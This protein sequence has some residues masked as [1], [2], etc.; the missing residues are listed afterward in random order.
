MAQSHDATNTGCCFTP[1]S[2]RLTFVHHFCLYKIIN[3]LT[4]STQ[5]TS[6][7]ADSWNAVCETWSQHDKDSPHKVRERDSSSYKHSTYSLY[8]YADSMYTCTCI[9]TNVQVHVVKCTYMYI[10]T[11]M[12]CQF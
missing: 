11:C 3:Y 7:I 2:L 5:P 1:I 9:C 8:M 10:Y 12:E 6:T 4:H